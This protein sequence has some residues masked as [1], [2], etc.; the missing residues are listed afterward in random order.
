MHAT[1]CE[2]VLK[3]PAIAAAVTRMAQT[4][5]A[6]MQ[7]GMRRLMKTGEAAMVPISLKPRGVI[8]G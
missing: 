8:E 2:T 7:N 1:S 5:A 4:G 3:L 6:A